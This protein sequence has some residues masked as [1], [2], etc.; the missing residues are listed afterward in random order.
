MTQDDRQTMF[1]GIGIS[2]DTQFG[3]ALIGQIA[4]EVLGNGIGKYDGF[5]NGLFFLSN[6]KY[7][8]KV[9]KYLA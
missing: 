5:Q 7:K 1:L 2:D 4:P 6:L 3:K 9:R 8:V